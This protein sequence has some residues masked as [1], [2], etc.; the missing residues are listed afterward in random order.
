[1]YFDDPTTGVLT[2]YGFSKSSAEDRLQ[3][4]GKQKNRQ[5]A[6]LLVEAYEEFEDY[7]E[8]IYAYIGKREVN[9]WYLDDFGKIRLADLSHK[10][11]A[12]YLDAVRRKYHGA[13]KRILN[14]LRTLYPELEIVEKTNALQV[15]LRV[16][17]ELTRQLQ[18]N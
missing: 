2:P 9:D 17:I 4:I 3:L 6:W 11:F 8:H 1:M 14:R 7:I 12:W 16:A 5:Y 13:S 10:D 18:K 15:N